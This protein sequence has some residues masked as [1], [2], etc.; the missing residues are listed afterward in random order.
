MA[1]EHPNYGTCSTCT[2]GKGVTKYGRMK[3]HN[4]LVAAGSAQMTVRCA[5]SGKLYAEAM[6]NFWDASRHGGLGQWKRFP[7]EVPITMH[8]LNGEIDDD[9]VIPLAYHADR[10]ETVLEEWEHDAI[11]VHAVQLENDRVRLEL[12]QDGTE[13]LKVETVDN[14]GAHPNGLVLR[15]VETAHD[16][17]QAKGSTK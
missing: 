6:G 1:K 12:L 4:R 17:M 13:V 11:R 5:G 9:V 3:E 2:Q 14:D 10:H 7:V 16:E 8:A 15:W